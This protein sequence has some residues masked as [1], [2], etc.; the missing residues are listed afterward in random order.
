MSLENVRQRNA[1]YRELK[2]TTKIVEDHV[3]VK[4]DNDGIVDLCDN[5][6]VLPYACTTKTTKSKRKQLIGIDEYDTGAEVP[7]KI[8]LVRTGIVDLSLDVDHAAINVGD[9][10]IVGPADI[11]RVVKGDHTDAAEFKRRVA[12]AEEK[13]AVPGS[14]QRTQTTIKASLDFTRGAL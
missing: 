12:W 11:G 14:G 7:G 8:K 1:I 4:T 13:V 6:E 3:I 5:A 9:M 2:S 10:L